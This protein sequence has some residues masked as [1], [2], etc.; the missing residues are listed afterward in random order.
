MGV[1]VR[2][3]RALVSGW[4]PSLLVNCYLENKFH[5]KFRLVLYLGGSEVDFHFFYCF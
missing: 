5:K 4:G 1:A 2:V 3:P